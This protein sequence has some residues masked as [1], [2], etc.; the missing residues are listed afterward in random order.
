M[1]RPMELVRSGALT[2]VAALAL[3][4]AQ[5]GLAG[6]QAV[7]TE[8][9]P[10]QMSTILTAMGLEVSQASGAP[11]G[12]PA[13]LLVELGGYRALVF[14]LNDNTDAQLYTV[15]PGRNAGTDLMNRWN[16]DY[17]FARA[18][19]DDEGDPVL[20][21]DLDFVGGVTEETI[22]AWVRLFRDNV[23]DYAAHVD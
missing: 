11:E 16:R 22:K 9:S 10:E 1:Y 20:E 8:V 7:M 18:Y 13:P 6:A 17:R 2:L 5:P 14:L 3:C 4:V 12:G 23:M 19:R 21:A 15:F